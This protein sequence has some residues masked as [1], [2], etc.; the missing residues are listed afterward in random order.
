M[1]TVIY[2]GKFVFGF[3]ALGVIQ[4]A[5]ILAV[6]GVLA[7]GAKLVQWINEQ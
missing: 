5:L 2:I 6:V 3:F 7:A 4:M 1:D